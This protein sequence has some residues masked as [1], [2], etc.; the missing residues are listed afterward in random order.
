GVSAGSRFTVRGTIGQP[1]VGAPV[2]TGDNYS[3]TG[4]FWSVVGSLSLNLPK[5]AIASAGP[6]LASISWTPDP[7]GFLLQ[8]S[9]DLQPPNWLNAPSG[10]NNPVTV[11][12]SAASRFYRLFKP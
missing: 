5:L 1:D 2:L 12:A 6:G 10:T 11:P 4:G 3:L 8:E 7:P 9:S